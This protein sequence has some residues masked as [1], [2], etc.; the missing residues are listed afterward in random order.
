[1]NLVKL[2]VFFFIIMNSYLFSGLAPLALTSF[3]ISSASLLADVTREE[4]IDIVNGVIS[5][6]TLDHEARAFLTMTPLAPGAVVAPFDEPTRAKTITAPTWFAYID[7]EP[8]AFFAHKVRY[9]FIDAASGAV[10][11]V[12]QQWWPEVDG[13]TPFSRD[14]VAALPALRIFSSRLVPSVNP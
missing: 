12:A 7:D 6:A 2:I 14:A 3:L 1:M 9:V 5:P 4:A 10:T 13:A 8:D 11:V